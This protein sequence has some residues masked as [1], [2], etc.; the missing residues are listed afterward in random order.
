MSRPSPTI[1][2]TYVTPEVTIQI[3][4]STGAWAVM[5]KGQGINVRRV[6]A[7]GETAFQYSRTVF[8]TKGHAVILA[9]KLNALAEEDLYEVVNLMKDNAND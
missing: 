3:L 5:R 8:P 4:E 2:D 6:Y 1:L 7:A 9:N